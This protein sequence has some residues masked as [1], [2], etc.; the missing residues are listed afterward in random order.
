VHFHLLDGDARHV[1]AGNK[2]PGCHRGSVVHR[3]APTPPGY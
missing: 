1:P 3:R 2:T